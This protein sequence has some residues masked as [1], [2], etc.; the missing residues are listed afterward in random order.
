MAEVQSR[1]LLELVGARSLAPNVRELRL[2]VVEGAPLVYAA[3]QWLKLY[4]GD[5]LDRDYSIASASDPSRPG[6]LELAVTLVEGGPGSQLL[7]AMPLGARVWSSGPSGF[8][9]RE[10]EHR[11]LPALFVATGTGLAPIR[12]MLQEELRSPAGP[13]LRLLFGCR[14][15]ADLLWRD[16]LDAWAASR[17]RFRWEAT[18]SRPPEGWTGRSGYVQAHLHELVQGPA[19]VYVCGLS[20]MV[21]EVRAALKR[22]GLDRRSIHSERYD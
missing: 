15:P 19:H 4:L 7:H 20:R 8:F 13:P 22:L 17:A 5:G 3:G 2:R 16:E 21:G 18:L 10:P 9:V 6:E 11:G 14:T 1:R 12:A